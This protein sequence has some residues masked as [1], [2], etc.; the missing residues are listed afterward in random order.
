MFMASNFSKILRRKNFKKLGGRCAPEPHAPVSTPLGGRR[1][2][3]VF[4]FYVK[5]W[6]SYLVHR[7]RAFHQ[8][9]EVAFSIAGNFVRRERARM[10]P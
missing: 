5:W 2:N 4:Q 9:A 3:R 7:P 1:G 6:P 8:N 10:S